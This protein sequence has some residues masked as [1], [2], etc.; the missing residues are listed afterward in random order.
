VSKKSVIARQV[1]RE[2]LIDKHVE[3]R[4]KLRAVVNSQTASYEETMDAMLA[5]QKLPRDS[6]KVRSVNRC[7]LTGRPKGVYRKFKMCR[8]MLRLFAMNGSIPGLTK[9]SW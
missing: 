6:S 3:I 1:K 4:A 2:A 9:A 7:Q 5:L 8:N